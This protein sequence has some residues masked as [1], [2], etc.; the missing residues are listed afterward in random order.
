MTN[1]LLAGRKIHHILVS[2]K[3]SF[4]N[5]FETRIRCHDK[6]YFQPGF[7]HWSYGVRKTHDILVSKTT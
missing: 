5:Q 1:W 3:M 7:S 2:K 4:F 6:K